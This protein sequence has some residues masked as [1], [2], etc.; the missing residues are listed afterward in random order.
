MRAL[1]PATRQ[2][3]N[4]QRRDA[5]IVSTILGPTLLLTAKLVIDPDQRPPS[6]PSR[7]RTKLRR[8]AEP[9]TAIGNLND[10]KLGQPQMWRDP[11]RSDPTPTGR[12]D[13]LNASIQQLLQPHTVLR[14]KPRR[15]PS[16]RAVRTK[17]IELIRLITQAGQTLDTAADPR[18]ISSQH[19]IDIKGDDR[20]VHTR[21]TPLHMGHAATT[22]HPVS[23]R[24]PKQVQQVLNYAA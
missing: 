5:V 15:T 9:R 19:P 12:P 8:P 13:Q 7:N 22:W 18:R 20:T 1:Q 14:V 23:H 11:L 24:L 10:R 2:R 6:G 16:R 17:A 21:T 3:L 4:D